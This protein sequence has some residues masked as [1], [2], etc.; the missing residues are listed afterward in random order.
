MKS[1]YRR[2]NIYFK[3]VFW[4]VLITL[5]ITIALIPLF[6][7]NLMEYP[8]GILTGGVFGAL[9][10]LAAGFNQREKNTRQGMTIDIVLIVMRFILLAGVFFALA[11]L[12]YKGNIHVIN[13]FA[14]IGAYLISVPMYLILFGKEKNK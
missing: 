14:F 6:F 9:Y 7:L 3:T 8:L 2:L 13:I 1:W 5:G 12:Y 4:T 10:Y 11:W